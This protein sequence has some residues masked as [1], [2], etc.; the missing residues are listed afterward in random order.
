MPRFGPGHK[1]DTWRDLIFVDGIETAD[2]LKPDAREL[3]KLSRLYNGAGGCRRPTWR[4]W[5][6]N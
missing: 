3:A 4:R 5:D 1:R 2:D 6:C